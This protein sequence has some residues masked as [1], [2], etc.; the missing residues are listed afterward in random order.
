VFD[1]NTYKKNQIFDVCKEIRNCLCIGKKKFGIYL[2]EN[3]NLGKNAH[4]KG[5]TV[6]LETI[7]NQL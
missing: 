4:S 1:L 5:K 2:L 6:T 3:T 7:L